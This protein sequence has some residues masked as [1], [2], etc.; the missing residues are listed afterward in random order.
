MY[1][2]RNRK[3]SVKHCIL[4]NLFDTLFYEEDV[5]TFIP[6]TIDVYKENTRMKYMV[7]NIK[8]YIKI[9]N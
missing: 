7:K 6:K 8:T 1:R 4:I 2:N 9:K 5:N 3:Y